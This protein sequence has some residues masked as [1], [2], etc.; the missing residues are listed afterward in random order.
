MKLLFDL[1]P[2]LLFFI[3]FKL[4]G[5]YTATITIMAATALQIGISWLLYHRIERMHV[6]TL[7]IV[8]AFGGAT[9][10]LHDEQFIKLKP[11]A[12]AWIFATALIISQWVGSKPIIQR[13]MQG[14][15]SLP[16]SLWRKLN[17]AWSGF[18][19][20]LGGVNLAVA[21]FFETS[22]WVNFKLYGVFGLTLL[23]AI[24]QALIISHFAPQAGVKEES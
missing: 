2:T 10:Y 18:F 15:F 16:P 7:G 3:V 24:S 23:F 17:W 14:Q 5:I 12:V 1:F 11:T 20:V 8:L 4:D 22:T 21:S 9:L 19:V 6:I 13:M